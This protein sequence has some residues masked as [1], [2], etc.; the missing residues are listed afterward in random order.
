MIRNN[1]RLRYIGRTH[2]LPPDVQDKMRWAEE[3]TAA[4][5]ALR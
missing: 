4:I 3:T 5:P 2:D 1:I